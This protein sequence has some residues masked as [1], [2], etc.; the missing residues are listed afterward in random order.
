[1]TA[2][3]KGEEEKVPRRRSLVRPG[4]KLATAERITLATDS[5]MERITEKRFQNLAVR[6][7]GSYI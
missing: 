6:R 2:T 4:L 5:T 7:K 3:E 1:M